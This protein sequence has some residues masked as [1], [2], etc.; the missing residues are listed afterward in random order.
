MFYAS[1]RDKYTWLI[2]KFIASWLVYAKENQIK[3]F[4][5]SVTS[6]YISISERGLIFNFNFLA[7]ISSWRQNQFFHPHSCTNTLDVNVH[8]TFMGNDIIE[9]KNFEVYWERDIEHEV[10]TTL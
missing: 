8:G 2:K 3:N 10:Y 5:K 1:N 6:G 9:S 4:C 7:E